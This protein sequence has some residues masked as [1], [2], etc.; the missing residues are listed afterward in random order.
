MTPLTMNSVAQD[1]TSVAKEP[2]MSL[3]ASDTSASAIVDA[4]VL[5]G[6]L[7]R[8]VPRDLLDKAQER[9]RRRLGVAEDSLRRCAEALAVE[10][11]AI[12]LAVIERERSIASHR[13][14]ID[15]V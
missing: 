5:A 2:V 1:G 13:Q 9:Q 10:L 11:Q 8:D 15:A 6:M 12:E 3:D 4:C 14:E 7:D